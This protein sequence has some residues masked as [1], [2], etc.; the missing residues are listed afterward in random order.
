MVTTA[1]LSARGQL[2][3]GAKDIAGYLGNLT[4]DQVYHLISE[5]R[6]PAFKIGRTVCARTSTLDRWLEEQERATTAAA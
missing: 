4:I 6:L 5:G 3:Y 1:N 2:L